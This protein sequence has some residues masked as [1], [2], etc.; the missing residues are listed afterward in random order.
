MPGWLDKQISQVLDI[1]VQAV[2]R[3]R[4]QLAGEGFDAVLKR[5]EYSQKVSYKRL[6]GDG[7]AILFVLSYGKLSRCRSD[8][9]I[10]ILDDRM[11]SGVM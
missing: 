4:K 5:Q 10:S 11:V 1:T 6:Y 9:S 7:E 3:I 2:E 8:W